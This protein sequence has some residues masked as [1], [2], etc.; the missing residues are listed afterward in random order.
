IYLGTLSKVLAPGVRIGYMVGPAPLITEARA[1]RRLM[2][3]SAPLNNQRTAA[4]FLAEGHAQGLVKSLRA[5][6]RGRWEQVC[7]ALA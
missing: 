5:A 3:R 1:L 2:H 7:A 6:I 4:I